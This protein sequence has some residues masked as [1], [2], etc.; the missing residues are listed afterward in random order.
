MQHCPSLWQDT[1]GIHPVELYKLS[2]M[3]W[4]DDLRWFWRD[5]PRIIDQGLWYPVLYFKLTPEYWNTNF[6]SRKGNM[7]MWEHINPPVV[8][9]D[10]LIWGLYMVTNRLTCLN[11]MSYN[12]VDA[13]ECKD[14]SDLIKL[15]MHL[16]DDNP[17]G[18]DK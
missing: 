4:H 13:I 6:W 1:P 10:G 7:P 12:T 14:Q 2:P 18:Y 9:E 15:G 17:G 8:N 16:R 3:A 11:F 5:L